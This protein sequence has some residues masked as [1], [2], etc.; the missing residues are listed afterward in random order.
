MGSALGIEPHTVKTTALPMFFNGEYASAVWHCSTH[1]K[2]L[3][4]VL[5]ETCRIV[6]GCLQKYN[7]SCRKMLRHTIRHIAITH[8]MIGTSRLGKNK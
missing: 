6:T 2:K 7:S 3:D 5:N 4:T 8:H 1:T